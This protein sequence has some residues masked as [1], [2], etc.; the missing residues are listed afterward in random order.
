MGIKKLYIERTKP[1]ARN[2]FLLINLLNP[3]GHLVCHQV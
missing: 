1:W 3:K 2:V